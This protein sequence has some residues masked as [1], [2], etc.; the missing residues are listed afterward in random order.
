MAVCHEGDLSGDLGVG[1]LGGVLLG[2]N[3]L[4]LRL[5]FPLSSLRE[6]PG[7]ALL[8]DLAALSLLSRLGERELDLMQLV[9]RDHLVDGPGLGQADLGP[10]AGWDRLVEGIQQGSGVEAS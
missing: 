10:I 9:G 3:S 7:T 1:R 5:D 8:G 6:N 4:F 2:E